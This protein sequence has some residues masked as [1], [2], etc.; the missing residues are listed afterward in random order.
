MSNL[1]RAI[2]HEDGKI[3]I[4]IR[5][6]VLRYFTLFYYHVD[7]QPCQSNAVISIHCFCVTFHHQVDLHPIR[8]RNFGLGAARVVGRRRGGHIMGGTPVSSPPPPLGKDWKIGTLVIPLV[9][10]L[11]PPSFPGAERS[12]ISLTWRRAITAATRRGLA[13]RQ[14]LREGRGECPRTRID[15]S[16]IPRRIELNPRRGR[17]R[18]RIPMK[19]SF[20]AEGRK[21]RIAGHFSAK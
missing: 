16:A 12:A 7:L 20:S 9:R 17:R 21:Q 14:R 13:P 2:L 15:Y 5:F 19:Q 8:S 6:I 18:R 1:H 4:A 10:F 11:P 3:K